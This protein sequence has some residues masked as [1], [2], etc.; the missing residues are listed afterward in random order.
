MAQLSW[1]SGWPVSLYV[2]VWWT[3]HFVTQFFVSRVVHD[4]VDGQGAHHHLARAH[5][6]LL[7]RHG[8]LLLL[9]HL[10]AAK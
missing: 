1:T 5:T 9:L 7:R 10:V 6:P 8:L 2:F 3:S 4:G